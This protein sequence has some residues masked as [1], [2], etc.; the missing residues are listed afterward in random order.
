MTIQELYQ[1]AIKDVHNAEKQF[2]KAMPKLAKHAQSPELKDALELHKGQ[3]ETQVERLE[4]IA[5]EGGFKL[6]GKVCH[7][8]QGLVEEGEE[9]LKELKAGPVGDATII[10]CAQKNEHYEIAAYGTIAAWAKE[11]GEK[12]A[13][14]LL[15]ETLKEEEATDKI[16]TNLS[17]KIN[18]EAVAASSSA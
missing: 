3:S 14:A 16:L 5:K 9:H 1:D 10:A 17:K 13:L 12:D 18:K 2:L 7:A 11:F 15:N 6:A 8:A 4:Q